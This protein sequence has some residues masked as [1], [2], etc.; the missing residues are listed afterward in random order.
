MIGLMT[1]MSIQE[2]M[3]HIERIGRLHG[4]GLT[5]N[6]RDDGSV[7][8]KIFASKIL[9]HDLI[10]LLEKEFEFVHIERIDYEIA[11]GWFSR[12]LFKV[13]QYE[14][15]KLTEKELINSMEGTIYFNKERG[16]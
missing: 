16:D 13:F 8:V 2:E 4:V 10:K 6:L 7:G 12:L 15:N 5:T 1:A 3:D 14:M 9:G 11:S